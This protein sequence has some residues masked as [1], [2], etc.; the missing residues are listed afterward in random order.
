M[1][2]PGVSNRGIDY[3]MA[4]N[5]KKLVKNFVLVFWDQRGTGKSY[6]SKIKQETM[7]INQFIS[8]STELIDYLRDRFS[9]QK[10]FLAGHTWGSLLGLSLVH[11]Y[12]EVFHSY[13]G[14]SQIVSWAKND[15]LA[16]NWAKKEVAKRKNKKALDELN[17]IGQPPFIESTKQWTILRK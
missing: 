7:T 1:P 16:L 8:D 13:I 14:I 5:T 10:I 3:T 17:A 4:T 2:L 11:L 12:P 6:N 15:E 9:Q